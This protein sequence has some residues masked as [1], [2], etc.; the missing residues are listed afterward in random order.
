MKTKFQSTFYGIVVLVFIAI[1]QTVCAQGTAFTYQGQ[2]NSD[3]NAATGLYDFNFALYNAASTGTQQGSTLTTNAVPVTNGYFI[4]VLDFGSTF[5]GN[6]RWL[7]IG[8]RTNSGGA[9]TILTPRQP[10][11]PTPYATY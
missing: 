10:L 6:A 3:G 9:F 8:V 7:E 2:L 4:V 1:V 11:T 5:D